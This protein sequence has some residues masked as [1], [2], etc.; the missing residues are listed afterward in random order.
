[1]CF[2]IVCSNTAI[3]ADVIQRSSSQTEL[4]NSDMEILQLSVPVTSTADCY[5]GYNYTHAARIAVHTCKFL[6]TCP[7]TSRPTGVATTTHAAHEDQGYTS[8]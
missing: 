7:P 1:M 3:L 6:P 5:H 8:G 2:Y 4:F